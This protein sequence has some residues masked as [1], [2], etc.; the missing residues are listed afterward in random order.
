MLYWYR[1][2][3]CK[4]TCLADQ[5]S[6]L[7]QMCTKKIWKSS[8]RLQSACFLLANSVTHGNPW[9]VERFKR[10]AD[11]VTTYWKRPIRFHALSW[12]R[13]SFKP[14][15]T[16]KSLLL[17]VSLRTS[18]KFIV[19]VT[20]SQMSFTRNESISSSENEHSNHH[21][22]HSTVD[23]QVIFSPWYS[24]WSEIGI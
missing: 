14:V 2:R 16:V 10:R 17:V 24:M 3:V 7:N 1:T 20:S 13:Y 9:T 21:L 22:D 5:F 19:S 11:E 15:F 18:V 12:G 23:V 6:I 8:S 4:M